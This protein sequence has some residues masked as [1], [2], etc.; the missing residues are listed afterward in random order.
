VSAR[1]GRIPALGSR[2]AVPSRIG[3]PTI[4]I[5]VLGAGAAA[6]AGVSMPEY[7]RALLAAAIALNLMVLGMRW[8]RAAAVAT[9]VF[10]PFLALIRRLLIEESG[11]T[12]NDPLLLVGPVVALF[13]LYR[14]YGA[15]ERRL[16]RDRIAL[17]TLALIVIVLLQVFNPLG[18]SGLIASLGGLL[19]LGVPLLWFFVGR[20]IA[21]DRLIRIVMYVVVA[22]ALVVCTY[23]L[24]QTELAPGE[25]L[26]PW[27][28]SWY[29][30]AGYQALDVGESGNRQIRPFSTFASNGEYSAYLSIGLII[31]FALAF[32]RRPL[33]L[34]AAPFLAF[35]VFSS[36]GRA[37]MALT[38]LAAVVLLGVRTR[39]LVVGFLVVV[40]GIA[41]VYGLASAFGPRLDRAAGLSGE[42]ISERNVSGL[43]HP[44]DPS[45]SSAL[46]RWDGFVDGIE[47]GIANP[48]GF[49]TAATNNASR[50]LSSSGVVETDNDVADA[51]VS[52][53]LAGGLVFL[54]IIILSFRAVFTRYSRESK[55]MVFA[56]AGIMIVM[57]GG[58][59]NGGL[60]ALAPLTWFLLGWATRPSGE[61]LEERSTG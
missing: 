18:S 28:Q 39:N 59:L 2:S 12:P 15:G 13:L 60:Y 58:W 16:D 55:W 41:S 42:A 49:G 29:E 9:L 14:I 43:L 46:S 52:L 53:G 24:F 36:G 35:A 19:F 4:A 40:V 30:V 17:L 5:T 3:W 27:D 23:G 8:P 48:A 10:L 47:E 11:W 37:V 22:V 54:A 31:I 7:Y 38:A 33:W 1:L 44:L 21:D 50:N 51:F 45:R 20:G 34:L 26:P 57:F 61:G 32:H 25:R 56:V 6:Y